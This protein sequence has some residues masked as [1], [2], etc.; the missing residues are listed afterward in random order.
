MVMKRIPASSF[1]ARCLRL[2]DEVSLTGE[3]IEVTKRG[4]AVARVVPVERPP[5]LEGSV[6]Y[7]VSDEELIAPIDVE[8]DADRD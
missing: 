2:L 5:S 6:A 3:E 7:H 8:W 4:R 1:K